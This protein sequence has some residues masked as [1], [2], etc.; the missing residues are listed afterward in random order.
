M[1]KCGN[2]LTSCFCVEWYS[3]CRYAS[4]VSNTLKSQERMQ[5]THYPCG[6]CIITLC[7]IMPHCEQKKIF[8]DI[9]MKGNS[10]SWQETKSAGHHSPPSLHCVC[11][12]IIVTFLL[13]WERSSTHR[14]HQSKLQTWYWWINK[15]DYCKEDS[16]VIKLCIFLCWW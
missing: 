9:I 11:I 10:L 16:S 7:L 3:Y 8:I 1:L 14:F 6:K 2:S 12:L 13:Q 15:L 4:R 5:W